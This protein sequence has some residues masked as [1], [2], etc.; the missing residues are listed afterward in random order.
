M[1]AKLAMGVLLV[2]LAI[3]A[4]P[5][6]AKAACGPYFGHPYCA[7]PWGYD[8]GQTYAHLSNNLPY[9]ALHPPVYYNYSVQ[10]PY[11][12]SP[13]A[14]RP[15]PIPAGYAATSP[16]AARG[17]DSP[18]GFVARPEPQPPVQPLRIINPYVLQAGNSG[19]TP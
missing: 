1:R 11:G 10:R 19:A 3:W 16:Q 12:Y 9:F 14:D 18:A 4:T 7:T 5:N 13:F 17:I 6:G 8:S 15:A 2:G